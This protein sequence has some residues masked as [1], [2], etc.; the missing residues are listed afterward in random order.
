MPYG[1]NPNSYLIK[2]ENFS[3]PWKKY[4]NCEPIVFS[5]AFLPKSGLFIRTLF[6]TIYELK[7]NGNWGSSIRFFFIRTGNYSHRSIESYAKETGIDDIVIELRERLPYLHILNLLSS[8]W[9]VM[10][11][12][13]TEKH[14]TASKV[15]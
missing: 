11:I 2:F 9:R 4:P 15:F 14:Y 1:S 13:S 3:Y 6:K 8:S 7:F 12:G 10:I 5:G